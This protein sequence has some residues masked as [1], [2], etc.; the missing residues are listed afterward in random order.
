MKLL[1]HE[2]RILDFIKLDI[3]ESE[4][5]AIPNMIETGN[6]QIF[7]KIRGFTGFRVKIKSCSAYFLGPGACATF[8]ASLYLT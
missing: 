5:E 7:F 4:Y 6:V 1:G 2:N 3:E 8:S